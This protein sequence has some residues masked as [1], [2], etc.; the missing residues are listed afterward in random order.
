M[1][2]ELKVQESELPAE[3]LLTKLAAEINA[4]KEQVKETVYMGTCRIGEKLLQAKGAVGHGNWGHW[5]AANVDYSERTAQKIITIYK[6]FNNKEQKLF[7]SGPDEEL[8]AKLNQSQLLALTS[9]KDEDQRNDFMEEH[10]EDLPD[11]SKS[12]LEK[13][14]QDLKTENQTEKAKRAEAE[15]ELEN[16]KAEITSLKEALANSDASASKEL[17]ELKAKASQLE[18]DLKKSDKQHEQMALEIDEAKTEAELAKADR[19]KAVVEAKKLKKALEQERNKPVTTVEV[20]KIVE[21]MPED[22]AQEL[23]Q[24]KRR[25]K[26]IEKNQVT[27]TPKEKQFARH[28]EN[29]RYEIEAMLSQVMVMEPEKKNKYG[30]IARK[31]FQQVLDMTSW[32]EE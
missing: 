10:K 6:N 3:E 18:A 1:S 7:G 8:L 24:L 23:E 20:E 32:A 31:M 29:A 28:Y 22:K 15:A 14:I 25:I 26:D 11:M 13:A 19:E 30:S 16:H 27:R 21:K 9:I 17:E 4:I 5:L 12:E 2:D